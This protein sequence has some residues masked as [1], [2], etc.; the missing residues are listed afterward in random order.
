MIQ[1]FYFWVYSK[2]TE[3]RELSRYLYPHV[4]SNIIQNSQKVK[5]TQV[6]LTDECIKMWY[7][8][9]TKYYSAIKKE[10]LTHAMTWINLGNI[11]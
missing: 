2:R 10:I 5:A 6:P 8:C 7:I 4:H 3:S 9:T 11:K 1:Q